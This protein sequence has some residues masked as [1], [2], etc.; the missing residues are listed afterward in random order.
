MDL[1][2]VRDLDS[3][4][5]TSN[6][7]RAAEMNHISQPAFS[8][9]IKALETWVGA[10]LVDRSTNP[11]NLTAAGLQILEAGTQ[12][13]SRIEAERDQIREAQAQ[14][15]RYLVTF[16][17]QHSIGWRFYPA[18]LQE[19]ESSFGPIMSRLRADDL[20]NCVAA[21]DAGDADFVIAFA[22]SVSPGIE[23][24]ADTESVVIGHDL[25]LPVCKSAQRG[26]P[27]FNLDRDKS[28]LIPYLKFGEVAPIRQHIDPLLDKLDLTR[29]L[30]TQYE[31]SMAGALRIKARNGVGVAW[32][33]KSLVQPD[34]D[35]GDLVLAGKPRWSIKLAI[36][37]HRNA[38]RTNSLTRK[39][40]SHMSSQEP[41]IEA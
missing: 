11:V 25:L 29:R 33:P 7:S 3:L 16:A 22:S 30:D 20:P 6:F 2:W 34:L 37:L 19:V 4:S 31:N 18:W 38:S 27:L 21:L 14:P 32:L 1:A 39:F 15:D 36:R 24:S 9:R 35:S 23:A 41:L 8:R 13:V 28:S 5:K 26:R 10:E 40:W 12:A 17:T